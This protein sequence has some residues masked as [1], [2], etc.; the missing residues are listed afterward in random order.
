MNRDHLYNLLPPIYR[1]RDFEQGSPL[2]ML[3]RIITEQAN[4]LEDDIAQLYENWFIE[5]CQDWV[6]PY[7]GDLV[8]YQPVHQAGEDGA[9]G[10]RSLENVLFPRREVANTIR[11]RRRKGTLSLLQELAEAVAGWPARVVETD[12]FGSIVQSV[13]HLRTQRG[14]TVDL[15]DS[16]AMDAIETPFSSLSSGVSLRPAPPASNLAGVT[17]YAWRLQAYPV[18]RTS[19]YCL[20]EV[21]DHCFL[22]SSTGSDTPLYHQPQASSGQQHADAEAELPIPITRRALAQPVPEKPLQRMASELFYGEAKSVAIWAGDWAH[23]DPKLPVPAKKVVPADLSDWAYRPEPGYVALDPE[24]GRLAFPPGQLPPQV[25]V[26]YSYGFAANLGGGAYPRKTLQP[27]G[28]SGIYS[29]G[30]GEHFRTIHT[31]YEAWR[32]ETEQFVTDN[33][34]VKPPR[35]ILEII[36]SGVYEERLHI[37][38][39]ENQTLELRAASGTRPSIFLADWHASQPDALTISGASQSEF[40]LEGMLV[41]G[42]GIE[43]TGSI[44]SVS[45]HHC[46][47]VPGWFLHADRRPRR[48]G[49]PSVT[50]SQTGASLTI[51]HSIVG[52]IRVNQNDLEAEPLRIDVRDSILDAT[53]RT[54]AAIS[55]TENSIAPAL[56]SLRR[57]TVLGALRTHAIQLAENSIV[58]GPVTVARR[59][60]GCMRFCYV[61]ENSRTPKR[62]HCQPD[63][64]ESLLREAKAKEHLPPEELASLLAA[65]RRRVQPELLSERFGTPDFCRLAG[66]TAPEI[67]AGAEDESE[68]GVFHNLFQ[69]QREANLRARLEEYTPAGMN[70]VIIFAT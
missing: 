51:D 63:Q 57:C 59:Q 36:D 53:H 62:F 54:N 55:S 21:G 27:P 1:E 66:R 29:V 24:L 38:L 6:V 46:T 32:L 25:S 43:V 65:E 33:P 14:R 37:E 3:L 58:T 15:R 35:G 60:I 64:A 4:V 8:G 50:F 2:Q 11:Y 20:E 19:A 70:A 17:L 40:I 31:A 16:K 12:Q 47:L 30:K 52:P 42:R 39:G 41:S 10:G 67:L 68:M 18:T 48:G 13:N 34:G 9:A 26:A 28:K 56:L 44:E 49:E 23:C 45:L 22:F 5:T 7:L 69:A 61:P